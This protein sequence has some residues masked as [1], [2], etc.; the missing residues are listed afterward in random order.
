VR[1]C[2]QWPPSVLPSEVT[3]E[4]LP[5]ELKA[6][7]ELALAVVSQWGV[8]IQYLPEEL[9]A[10]KEVALAEHYSDGVLTSG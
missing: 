10:D 6:D 3:T 7:E 1:L 4:Y 8:A 5:E 9:K 2:R